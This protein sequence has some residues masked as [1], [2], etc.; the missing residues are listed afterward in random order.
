M[1]GWRRYGEALPAGR[2]GGAW[3]T[4]LAVEQFADAFV[5]NHAI[6]SGESWN[7]KKPYGGSVSRY[8]NSPT[9]HQWAL[10]PDGKFLLR[11]PNTGGRSGGLAAATSTFTP[12]S[13]GTATPTTTQVI[14]NFGLTIMLDWQAAIKK[15]KK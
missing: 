9:R 3:L 1:E 5:G 2:P 15:E 11:G 10:H 4:G 12:T 7:Q 14:P 6:S 13:A 8:G